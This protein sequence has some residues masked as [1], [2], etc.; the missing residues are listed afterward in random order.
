MTIRQK[1]INKNSII[2]FGK[3]KDKSVR[4]ILSVEPSYILWLHEKGIVEFP[5]DIVEEAEYLDDDDDYNGL[6]WGD[7]E[8]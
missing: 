8:F 3:Y 1:V 6:G 4:Y 2:T 7:L 5:D